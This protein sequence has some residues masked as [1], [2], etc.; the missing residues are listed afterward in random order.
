M[1]N[2]KRHIITFLLFHLVFT[3]V[4]LTSYKFFT[5]FTTEIFGHLLL[6]IIFLTF[7]ATFIQSFIFAIV[8]TNIRITQPLFFVI[9]FL[10]ELVLSNI[11]VVYIN[12]CDSF[13]KD[14]VENIRSHNTWSNLSGSLLFHLALIIST[15]II[16]LTRPVYKKTTA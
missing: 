5:D 4:L 12:G 1:Q 8:S 14:L 6:F 11:L 2:F 3:L 15:V 13:T 9:S 7:L 10:V 16:S